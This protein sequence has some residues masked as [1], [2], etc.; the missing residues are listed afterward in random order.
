MYITRWKPSSE[1]NR[2]AG[3]D[4]GVRNFLM[5]SCPKNHSRWIN[6]S[7]FSISAYPWLMPLVMGI[8]IKHIFQ[9]CSV[10]MIPPP[11]PGCRDS[12]SRSRSCN[13]VMF[14]FLHP[15]TFVPQCLVPELCRKSLQFSGMKLRSLWYQ[16]CQ[17][18][19]CESQRMRATGGKAL[20]NCKSSL[21]ANPSL[22]PCSVL[23]STLR[24]DAA[25]GGF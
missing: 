5:C 23:V 13:L 25:F 12:G 6:E 19:S 18:D 22:I 8:Y 4:F 11:P 24:R 17:C 1:W 21:L 15:F 10:M 9:Y 3:E 16:G 7:S 2:L 14:H 20:S